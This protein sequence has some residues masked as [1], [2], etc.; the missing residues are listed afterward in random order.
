MIILCVHIW[1]SESKYY[2]FDVFDTSNGIEAHSTG[3]AT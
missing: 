3:Q 1:K 2:Q